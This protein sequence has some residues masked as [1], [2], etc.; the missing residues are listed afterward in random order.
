MSAVPV[1]DDCVE[2]FNEMKLKHTKRYVVYRIEAERIIIDCQADSSATYEEFT[3]KLP[4]NEPRYAVVDFEYS[5]DDGR[6]QSKLLFVLWSPDS[7]AV[8]KKMV[9]AA[10]KDNIKRK[11]VGVAKELQANDRSEIAK[12]EVDKHMK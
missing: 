9:Y 11:L 4:D 7:G 8:K 6:P 12:D 5:T 1:D 3:T 2:M 10:S